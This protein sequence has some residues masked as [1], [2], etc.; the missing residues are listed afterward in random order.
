M[1]RLEPTTR[2]FDL[3]QKATRWTLTGLSAYLVIMAIISAISLYTPLVIRTCM[4]KNLTGK[5]C[6]GCGSTRM[7]FKVLEGKP[8]E[9]FLLNPFMF[10]LILVGVNLLLLKFL[11][12][13]KVCITAGARVQNG[14]WIGLACAFFA[15]W[16]Y[17]FNAGV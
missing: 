16:I 13:Q 9:A 7:V 8:A 5:P 6:G 12:K 3:R 1:F 2:F 10:V 4:F 17:V 15:N 11:F 14:I